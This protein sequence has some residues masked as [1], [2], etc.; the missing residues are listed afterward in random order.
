V[1]R[2][3][4][5]KLEQQDFATAIAHAATG[6][7]CFLD[8]TY[9]AIKHGPF[10]R[11]NPKLFTWSDQIRL[12]ATAEAAAKRGATVIVCNVDC[13]E[14][15]AL[16]LGQL[17]IPLGR[18]KAIGNAVKNSRALSSIGIPTLGNASASELIRLIAS[19]E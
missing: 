18:P 3:C 15:R 14:I 19:C 4:D 17:S 10:D 6:D 2:A 1:L 9:T 7:I 16:Y 11:Y 12:H 5:F 8:P 13:T